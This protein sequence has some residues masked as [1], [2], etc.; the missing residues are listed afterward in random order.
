MELWNYGRSVFHFLGT[1]SEN[2]LAKLFLEDVPKKSP[3]NIPKKQKTFR[4][5]YFDIE[6]FKTPHSSFN[7]SKSFLNTRF[8]TESSKFPS[9]LNLIFLI[10][11]I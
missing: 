11:L 6:K 4:L 9:L 7:C 8:S 10:N 3:K 5:N 2:S 1:P